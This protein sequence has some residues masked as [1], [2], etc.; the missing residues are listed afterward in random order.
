MKLAFAVLALLL[1]IPQA[2]ARP[3]ES[4][5]SFVAGFAAKALA[6]GVSR[7]TY[8]AAMGGLTPDPKTPGLVS[9]QP[10]FTTAVWDYIDVRVSPRRIANGQA[11]IER[12]KDL[13]TAVGQHYGVIPIC[14][15]RSGASKLI[16]ARCW[17]MPR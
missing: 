5:E 8:E 10:E 6:A 12:N 1:L 17:T 11:A 9:A 16:M 4:F 2:A 15:G 14:W 3:I 7:Q 13:F